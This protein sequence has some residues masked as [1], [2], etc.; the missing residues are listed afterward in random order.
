VSCSW[1]QSSLDDEFCLISPHHLILGSWLS[2]ST[3]FGNGDV[4]EDAWLTSRYASG[5]VDNWYGPGVG[6][7]LFGASAVIKQRSGG[8]SRWMLRRYSL[9]NTASR[10]G[11]GMNDPAANSP[12]PWCS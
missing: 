4:E 3:R 9:L 1:L 2:K 8:P 7:P 12:G 6:S 11:P 5:C 10:L